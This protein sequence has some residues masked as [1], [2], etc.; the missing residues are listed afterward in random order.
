MQKRSKGVTIL[1]WFLI[2][3]SITGT[4]INV[5]TFM[6]RPAF[7]AKYSTHL[8]RFDSELIYQI[9][10]I[11]GVAIRVFKFILGLNIL[12]LRETWRKITICYFLF[13]ILYML[14]PMFLLVNPTEGLGGFLAE[15]IINSLLIY[16]LIRPTTKEQ[17]ETV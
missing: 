12:K 8:F 11:F 13:D 5:Y 10:A 1:G 16:F 14:C 9:T 3:T 7:I 15:S 17:F 2:I 4:L 6:A